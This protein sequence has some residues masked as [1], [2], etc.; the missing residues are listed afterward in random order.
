MC[1]RVFFMYFSL[2]FC[3]VGLISDPVL[4]GGTI[5]G[6]LTIISGIVPYVSMIAVNQSV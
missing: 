5:G 4:E 2:F 6:R 3:Y 1:F